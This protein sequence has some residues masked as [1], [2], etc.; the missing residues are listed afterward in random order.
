MPIFFLTSLAFL[1]NFNVSHDTVGTTTGCWNGRYRFESQRSP[2]FFNSNITT[3]TSDTPPSYASQ[4]SIPEL[5]W[6]QQVLL[7]ELFWYCETKHFR[8]KIVIPAPSLIPID[9]WY[10]EDCETLK[11]SPTKSFGNLDTPSLPLSSQNFFDAGIFLKH[12]TEGF[13][14]EVFRYC[15][16]KKI[17]EAPRYPP[18][19]MHEEFLH[20]TFSPT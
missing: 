6:N 11:Y 13:L 15:E 16:T 9:F 2:E 4:I 18:L 5:F 10:P 14:Y 20:Q 1:S 7:Y 12:S 17:D 3:E 19:L 8:R